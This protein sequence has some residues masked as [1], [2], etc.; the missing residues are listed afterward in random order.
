[1]EPRFS[2]LSPELQRATSVSPVPTAMFSFSSTG[3][4]P[5]QHHAPAI[6]ISTDLESKA[7]R[8]NSV[9]KV[10]GTVRLDANPADDSFVAPVDLGIAIDISA[11]MRVDSKLVWI[12]TRALKSSSTCPIFPPCVRLAPPGSRHASFLVC[13]YFSRRITFIFWNFD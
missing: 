11:S 9:H 10:W 1:F 5:P 13:I 2:P 6:K 7:L 4:A 3:A 12:S 8:A